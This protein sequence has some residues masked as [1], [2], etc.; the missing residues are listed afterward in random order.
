M[1]LGEF[2]GFVTE[3]LVEVPGGRL[4]DHLCEI[5]LLGLRYLNVMDKK[6]KD[7]FTSAL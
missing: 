5:L 4:P 6:V 7:G 3:E 2:L 1:T